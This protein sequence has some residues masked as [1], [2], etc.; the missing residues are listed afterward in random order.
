MSKNFTTDMTTKTDS[1]NS[2][3]ILRI[4]KQN[5]LLKFMEIKTNEPTLTQKT[6]F[7]TTR[8]LR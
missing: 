2:I 3:S 4:F 5:S 8:L 1:L 6:I 7:K